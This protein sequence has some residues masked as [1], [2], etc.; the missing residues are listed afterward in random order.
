MSTVIFLIPV[1]LISEAKWGGAVGLTH[2][3]FL[4]FC[5][6]TNISVRIISLLAEK[7]QVFIEIQRGSVG[8]LR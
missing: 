2:Y 5:R 3:Y 6:I 4:N 1:S 8:Y 7:V